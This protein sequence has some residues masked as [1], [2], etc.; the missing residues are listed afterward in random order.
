MR[1]L[2]DSSAGNRRQNLPRDLIVS[3]LAEDGVVALGQLECAGLSEGAIQRSL[4]AGR[5]HVVL[6]GVYAVGH[7]SLSWRGRLRAAVLWG[8][9]DAVL[10]HITAAG[11]WDLL[12]SATP[13]VHITIPRGG[14]TS[15]GW[16]RVHHTRE[17]D[18]AEV[19]GFPVTSL[20]RTLIDLAPLVSQ[21]RLEQAIEQAVRRGHLDFRALTQT[22][23]RRGAAKLHSLTGQFDPLAPH[24]N[25]GTERRFL[26]FIRQYKLPEP[27]A[28]VQVGP[29][30][31]DFLWPEQKVIVELDSLAHHRRPTVFEQDRKRDIDL[32]RRFRHEVLRV[33]DRRLKTEPAA[34]AEELRYFLSVCG[35]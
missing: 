8:G 13:N 12:S 10:S 4:N 33:T 1:E 9:P 6:P 26:R 20:E 16:V 31:V 21:D 29:Y 7:S 24:T 27:R 22:R 34:V 25:P 30:V 11:L 5:L 14:K 3:Q 19:N 35:P 2:A 18:R 23:G 17:L 28:N 15:R 32:K